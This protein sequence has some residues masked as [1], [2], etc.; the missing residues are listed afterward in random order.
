[1]GCFFHVHINVV[2]SQW[3]IWSGNAKMA[4]MAKWLLIG[5]SIFSVDFYRPLF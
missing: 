2:I 5:E 1:V 4:A 3:R